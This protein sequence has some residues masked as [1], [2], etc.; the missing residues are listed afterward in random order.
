[1]SKI[2]GNCGNTLNDND[3]VCANCGA[4]A[5]VQK[6]AAGWTPLRICMVVAAALLILA[7]F[8]PFASTSVFGTTFS[9]SLIEG[10]DGVF[11]IVIAAVAIVFT[12]LNKCLV[13]MICGIAACVLSIF[14]LISWNTQVGE[15]SGVIS[16]G[17]GFFLMFIASIAMLVV[18][19]LRFMQSKK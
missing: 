5:P 15:L 9:V 19:I 12:L 17:F 3:V 18:G 11:F 7:V 16:K 4:A 13:E 1:M 2:C 6:K 10:S 14:E 8:L